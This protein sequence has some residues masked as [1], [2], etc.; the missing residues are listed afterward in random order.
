MTRIRLTAPVER[1]CVQLARI[2]LAAAARAARRLQNPR[3]GEAL[4]DFRV[5][6]RRLR[7]LLR[8]YRKHLRP[9]P[10]K[11]RRGLRRLARDTNR[12]RDAEVALAWVQRSMRRL[13]V[14]ARPAL[15]G[16]RERLR[17]ECDEAYSEIRTEAHAEFASLHRGFA[18]AFGQIKPGAKP[19]CY[20]EAVGRRIAE[21]A[22]ALEGA[23]GSIAH[24]GQSAAIHAARI[25]GKRLRYLIEPL[26]PG[27]PEAQR[28]VRALKKFQDRFGLLCDAFVRGESLRAATDAQAP[29]GGS[30]AGARASLVRHVRKDAERR[31]LEVKRHHLG[32]RAGTIVRTARAVA[33]ALVGSSPSGERRRRVLPARRARG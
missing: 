18:A 5:A 3:D 1:A 32:A 20:A 15:A 16:W 22:D 11:L 10:K 12:A 27:L 31:Y 8:A 21:H 14:V 24:I 28:A 23:L 29:D 17:R 9:L 6:L 30:S 19:R 33:A 13:P 4:H 7:S 25:E 26:A 2:H